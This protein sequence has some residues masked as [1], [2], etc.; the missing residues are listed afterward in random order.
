MSAKLA[1]QLR[2][3]ALMLPDQAQMLF[4]A[5]RALEGEPLG[6]ISP[7][8][9]NQLRMGRDALIAPVRRNESFKPVW[10]KGN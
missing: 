4:E 2:Q 8:E 6:F 5:A 7:A 1:D 3:A 9:I 10:T